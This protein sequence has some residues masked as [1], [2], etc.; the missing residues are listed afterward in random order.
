MAGGERFDA[1]I[2][3]RDPD[4]LEEPRDRSPAA[5]SSAGE[6][7][8]REKLIKGNGGL[9]SAILPAGM[10]AV[11]I[12]IDTRGASSAGGFILPNDR[13][14]VIRT[15]SRRPPASGVDLHMSETILTNIRVLAIGQTIQE[16]T[17]R[18]S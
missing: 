4:G 7:I 9:L 13:V 1:L 18:R 12:T 16:R 2:R 11:A 5:A 10:R 6:P 15:R 8:R 3:K 14:D 17:A